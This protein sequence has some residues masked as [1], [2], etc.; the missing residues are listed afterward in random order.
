MTKAIAFKDGE[1]WG[2]LVIGNNTA[3]VVDLT[4]TGNRKVGTND[5]WFDVSG[6][7]TSQSSDFANPWVN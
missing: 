7:T 6:V 1:P 5:H 4:V 3:S 2:I